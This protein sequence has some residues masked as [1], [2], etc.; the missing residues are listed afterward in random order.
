MPDLL[1][2]IR[3][4]SAPLQPL[5]TQAKRSLSLLKDIRAV[6]FDVY[7]TLFISSAGDISLSKLERCRHLLR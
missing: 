7:G 3:E 5:P 4:H 6:L 1:S 2:I